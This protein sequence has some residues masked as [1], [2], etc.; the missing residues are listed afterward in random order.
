MPTTT[1]I[2]LTDEVARRVAALAAAAEQPVE[3]FIE[4]LLRGLADA[5]VDF[6]QGL[7]VFRMPAEAPPLTTTEVD[8]LLNGDEG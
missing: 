2:T 1:T 3:A 6:E 7:P 5:D 8:R 4:R